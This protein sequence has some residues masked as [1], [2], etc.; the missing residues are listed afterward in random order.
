M[1][2]PMSKG[3]L[4][5]VLSFLVVLA[6]GADGAE[7]M[8]TGDLVGGSVLLSTTPLGPRDAYSNPLGFSLFY[9]SARFLPRRELRLG[10][11]LS[12][13][14]MLPRRS[15]FGTSVMLLPAL[16]GRLETPR[17]S[18]APGVVFSPFV[19]LG[20]YLRWYS[21]L[22]QTRFA[23]RPAFSLGGDLRLSVDSS[24][25]Y[26]AGVSY[27]LLWEETLRSLFSL[28]ISLGYRFEG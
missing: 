9:D 4:A 12:S 5:F 6:A 28:S 8:H 1:T 21:F 27:T 20:S 2:A 24:R 18:V 11:T 7:P 16:S 22:S 25:M 17:L 23:A 19:S 3:Y 15:Q 13:Y 14:Q 26:A 10:A